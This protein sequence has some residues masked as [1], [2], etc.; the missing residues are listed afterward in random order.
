[1]DA[2]FGKAIPTLRWIIEKLSSIAVHSKALLNR[3]T[4]A[5]T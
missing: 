2:G 1:M 3:L 5:E 4:A